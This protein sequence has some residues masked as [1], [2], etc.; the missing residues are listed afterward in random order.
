MNAGAAAVRTQMK[1]LMPVATA[2]I[3]AQA[4][5]EVLREKVNAIKQEVLNADEYVK[6]EGYGEDAERI[7]DPK[8]DW[9]MSDEAF[10]RYN[11]IVDARCRAEI[12]GAADLDEGFCPALVAENNLVKAEHALIKATAPLFDV[13]PEQINLDM[14]VRAE[15]IKTSLGLI[16]HA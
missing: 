16:I 12:P 7:T 11:A 5:A 10:A 3:E 6:P 4:M 8:Y 1:T 14:K 13:T 15:W 9:L 2:V